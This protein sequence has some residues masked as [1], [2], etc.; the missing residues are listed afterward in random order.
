MTVS[1]IAR[2][3]RRNNDNERD[4][5]GDANNISD[6]QDV[7]QDNGNERPAV[8]QSKH[9]RDPPPLPHPKRRRLT[10]TPMT[11]SAT[12]VPSAT[13]T[14][15]TIS[16]EPLSTLLPPLARQSRAC[17]A[18]KILSPSKSPHV[19]HRVLARPLSP[20]PH[21]DATEPL[22]SDHDVRNI[23]IQYPTASPSDGYNHLKVIEK[24]SQPSIKSKFPSWLTDISQRKNH[25]HTFLLKTLLIF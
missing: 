6:D 20:L 2:G 12:P 16:A 7:G 14:T 13:M 1:K 24:L 19:P 9:A 3:T 11:I 17:K 21:E 18:C 22:L 10:S 5:R 23:I 15:Q 25:S 4:E 8:L